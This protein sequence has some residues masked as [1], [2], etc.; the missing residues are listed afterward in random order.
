M[1]MLLILMYLLARVRSDNHQEREPIAGG[2]SFA[3]ASANPKRHGMRREISFLAG[4]SAQKSRKESPEHYPTSRI[5][6]ELRNIRASLGQRCGK[7]ARDRRR[8]RGNRRK[9]TRKLYRET[10]SVH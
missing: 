6:M 7:R 10:V 8:P 3:A 9:I 5:F 2:A 1:W 4:W